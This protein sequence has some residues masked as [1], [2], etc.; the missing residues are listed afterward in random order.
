MLW[1]R[2]SAS[3]LEVK[4]LAGL[5]SALDWVGLR[6][7]HQL[8]VL[9]LSGCCAARPSAGVGP[10]PADILHTPF[11]SLAAWRT[12]QEGRQQLAAEA[13]GPAA[14]EVEGEQPAAAAAAASGA[15]AEAGSPA[16]AALQRQILGAV[17]EECLLN[18]KAEVRAGLTCWVLAQ[19]G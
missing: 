14:M 19:L 7:S 5:G 3:V 12:E 16:Q 2:R 6:C 18:S 10:T 15:A 11:G 13:A 8:A 4:P 17:M 1:G 9:C